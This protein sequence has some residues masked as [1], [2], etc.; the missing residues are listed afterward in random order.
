MN[1]RDNPTLHVDTNQ[2]KGT[3]VYSCSKFLRHNRI[4]NNEHSSFPQ[5]SVK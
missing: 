2:S 5:M 4:F 1:T 3:A